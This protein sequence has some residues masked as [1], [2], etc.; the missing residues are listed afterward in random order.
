MKNIKGTTERDVEGQTWYRTAKDESQRK[1]QETGTTGGHLCMVA[2][3]HCKLK[4]R[5]GGGAL[6]KIKTVMSLAGKFIL[7][8]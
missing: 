2:T 3:P 7:L 4:M 8:F 5:G 6:G 1:M